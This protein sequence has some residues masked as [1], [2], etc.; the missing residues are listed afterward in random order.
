ML[1]TTQACR[2]NIPVFLCPDRDKRPRKER[3][4]LHQT[5]PG[6]F[7]RKKLAWTESH[8]DNGSQGSGITSST[9]NRWVCPG[10]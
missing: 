9:T 7:V 2:I 4:S 10:V 8:D 1:A 3:A 5:A 6:D